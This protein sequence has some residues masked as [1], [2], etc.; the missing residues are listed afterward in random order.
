MRDVCVFFSFCLE[1]K[2]P[3]LEKHPNNKNQQTNPKT[4]LRVCFFFR[5]FWFRW[6][7]RG[8]AMD[9][10]STPVQT[11]VPHPSPSWK[12]WWVDSMGFKL[13]EASFLGAFWNLLVRN[14]FTKKG[15]KNTPVSLDHIAI[16][17]NIPPPSW[18]IGNPSTQSGVTHLPA[19][20]VSLLEG[21][22]LGC[23]FCW[24][25]FFTDSIWW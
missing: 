12:G 25:M 23:V 19:S 7:F 13:K 24:W 15:G 17:W 22:R 4:I 2:N 1:L 8:L 9:W 16:C 3:I 5:T 10:F 18:P 11:S 14:D 20:Y 21:N 6:N